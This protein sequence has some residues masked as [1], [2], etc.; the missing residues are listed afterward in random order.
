MRTT[1]PVHNTLLHRNALPE[2]DRN[3]VMNASEFA[4]LADECQ[5]MK[6]LSVR[7]VVSIVTDVQVESDD[8]QDA[9][10]LLQNLPLS[11]PK[12]TY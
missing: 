12:S 7:Q 4:A 6:E 9:D 11:K 3:N 5:I 10:F 8:E 2:E 1:R